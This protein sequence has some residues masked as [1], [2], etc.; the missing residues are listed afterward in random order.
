MRFA[1]SRHHEVPKEVEYLESIGRKGSMTL[2]EGVNT[3]S[4]SVTVSLPYPEYSK[5]PPLVVNIMV[6]IRLPFRY[7]STNTEC[8]THF[9]VGFGQFNVGSE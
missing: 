3:G 4:A 7:L 1:E 2:L 5:I 6:I 9:R 8:V